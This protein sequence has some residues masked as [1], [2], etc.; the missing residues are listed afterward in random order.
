MLSLWY[1]VIVVQIKDTRTIFPKLNSYLPL[2]THLPFFVKVSLNLVTDFS[3]DD[4]TSEMK[5]ENI[6]TL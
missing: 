4:I 6:F 1:F 2:L 3:S 5:K